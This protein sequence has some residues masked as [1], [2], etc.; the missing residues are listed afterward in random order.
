MPFN[1]L[2]LPLL[3]GYVFI[4]QTDFSCYWSSRHSKE[5]LIFLSAVM[6]AFLLLLSRFIVYVFCFWKIGRDASKF[7]HHVLPFEGIGTAFV[8][9]IL[10]FIFRWWFNFAF[11]RDEAITWHYA[12]GTFNSLEQLLVKCS[13]RASPSALL[14]KHPW[15]I[16]VFALILGP[17]LRLLE[18]GIFIKIFRL[19]DSGKGIE[20]DLKSAPDPIPIMLCMKNRKIYVGY[21]YHCLAAR[22]ETKPYV[23]IVPMWSGYRDKDTL[24]VYPTQKYA[25]VISEIGKSNDR[26]V[27]ELFAKVIALDDIET[28]NLYDADSFA[29]FNTS[30]SCPLV[31]QYYPRHNL[32]IGNHRSARRESSDDFDW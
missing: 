27:V 19:L 6:G 22:A 21:V 26:D 13:Y 10:G 7:V 30:K 28:A 24:S 18:R 14:M 20:G 8:A 3:G 15:F 5:H 31:P 12:K 4:S 17:V 25:E 16:M 29:L 11:N 1:Q 23:S 32:T 2:L 9:F